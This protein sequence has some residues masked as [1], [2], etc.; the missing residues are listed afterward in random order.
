MCVYTQARRPVC[1]EG[2]I[3]LVGNTSG[4]SAFPLRRLEKLQHRRSRSDMVVAPELARALTEISLEIKRQVGLLL[5]RAGHVEAVLVGDAR[6]VTL[7]DLSAYKRGRDRLC[8]LR[9]VHTHLNHEPLSEDDMTDLAL[10]RL[11]MVAAVEVLDDG[12]PGRVFQANLLPDNERGLPWEILPPVSVHDLKPDFPE[13]IR[14]TEDEIERVRRPRLAGDTRDRAILVHVGNDTGSAAED[15]LDELHELARSAGLV[16]V[17]RVVQRRQTDP[18]F[19]M[20]KG[21]LKETLIKA[22]QVGAEAIIFD[23]NLSPAQVRSIADFTDLKVLDRT[24]VILDIF[25]QHAQTRE[26]KIQV[27]L[28]QLRY[29]LPRLGEKHTAMSRLTGGIGGRGP[30]ETK[31]EINRRR[32]QDRIA[33]LAREV[34]KLG[35]RRK[36]R[37][38]MRSRQGLPTVAIVGYTNAGK[39][40]LLNALTESSVVAENALFATLN[41]VSRRL[42]FP[43]ERNI[44][45]TDTVGFIR[46]LPEDLMAA[47]RTTC[48]E[49]QEADLL[50]HVVDASAGDVEEKWPAVRKILARLELDRK[51]T[52]V[53]LNKIDKCD[54]DRVAGLAQNYGAIPISARQP[55]T[56]APLL[57]EL[58]RKLWQGAAA[59]TSE[60]DEMASCS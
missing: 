59:R 30:G 31:L 15:S 51:P 25:A 27:E 18:R 23:L 9:L 21:K 8:G 16:T 28:A 3:R 36:L 47:F 10:L 53:V 49:A 34:E 38:S 6:A 1:L 60:S 55:E 33:Q 37:R 2:I 12:L 56:F 41:P 7:P 43:D 39:S 57:N 22:M 19:V 11:D 24:Q 17:H 52:V 29:L 46:N 35:D 32:A 44:I 14:A 48:E 20:G 42:R 45:I 54:P 26:G 50:L 5:D 40:T 4:L 13:R 58:N